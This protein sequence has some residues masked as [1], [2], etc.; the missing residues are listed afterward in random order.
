MRTLIFWF[1]N[2][3]ECAECGVIANWHR[4]WKWDKEY[5]ER[6]WRESEPVNANPETENNAE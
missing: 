2:L 4:M 1:L 5:C 6:C 3:G